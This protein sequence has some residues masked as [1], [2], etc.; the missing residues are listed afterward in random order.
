M[1][2][3]C[4]R[5]RIKGHLL[6]MAYELPIAVKPR[7]NLVLSSINQ[8]SSTDLFAVPVTGATNAYGSYIESKV[9]A[10]NK[11][12]T[13]SLLHYF[14]ASLLPLTFSNLRI[15]YPCSE[16]RLVSIEN[17]SSLSIPFAPNTSPW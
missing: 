4:Y 7:F 1:N 17:V 8:A 6:L 13:A 5:Q 12:Y 14:T 9:K 3:W 2:C 10:L 16:S 15:N 11:T